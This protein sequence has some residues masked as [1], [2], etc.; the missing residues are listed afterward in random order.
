M[1]G[2]SCDGHNGLGDPFGA[3]C[4]V[5]G[6]QGDEETLAVQIANDVSTKMLFARV[7]PEEGLMVNPFL[8]R[9]RKGKE[10]QND[11]CLTHRTS[12]DDEGS[13]RRRAILSKRELV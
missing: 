10:T 9:S 12:S 2:R 5:F 6:G 4:V 11:S 1:S 3:P 7:V 13:K 8:K